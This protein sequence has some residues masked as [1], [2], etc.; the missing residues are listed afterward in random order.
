MAKKKK[1]YVVWKGLKPGIYETWEETKLQILN[2]E[3]A[4]YKSFE[5]LNEAEIAFSR[6]YTE[7]IT[8]NSTLKKENKNLSKPEREMLENSISV[9]AACAGNPGIMEYRG[10]ITASGKE[11]FRQGPYRDGTN[12]IGEFLALVHALALLAKKDDSKTIIFTDSQTAMSWVK[13]KKVKSTLVQN[14]NNKILFELMDRALT[15]LHNNPIK[16]K[17]IKWET[18]IWGEIPADFGRK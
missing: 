17:I 12:N 3:G 9:D 16:N 6:N 7:Y 18:D 8:T 15:W 11:I 13:N 4:K 14:E 10:V 5:N 2:Y 1:Y